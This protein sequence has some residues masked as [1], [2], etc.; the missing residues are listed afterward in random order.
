M[1]PLDIVSGAVNRKLPGRLAVIQNDLRLG[2][3]VVYEDRWGVRHSDVLDDRDVNACD[4]MPEVA[5]CLLR[6]ARQFDQ[7]AS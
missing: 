5:V 6:W 3:D 2:T 4:G 1:M 7:R